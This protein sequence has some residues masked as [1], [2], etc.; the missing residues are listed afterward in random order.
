MMSKIV[1]NDVS[2]YNNALHMPLGIFD[3]SLSTDGK[4]KLVSA[5]ALECVFTTV[6]MIGV[7]LLGWSS[8]EFDPVQFNGKTFQFLGFIV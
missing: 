3:L 2:D 1:Y 6:S 4:C 5:I 8:F 7:A